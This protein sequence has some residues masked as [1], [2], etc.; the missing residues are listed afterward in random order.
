M[1]FIH[2]HVNICFIRCVL[3]IRYFPS[4]IVWFTKIL[5]YRFLIFTI[6]SL[7]F[8]KSIFLKMKN[9]CTEPACTWSKVTDG[10]TR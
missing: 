6:L 1:H 2:K 10:N 7:M 5:F 9:T 4:K 8:F 3:K